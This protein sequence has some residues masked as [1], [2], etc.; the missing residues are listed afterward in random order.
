MKLQ[1][2]HLNTN[3]LDIEEILADNVAKYTVSGKNANFLCPFHDDSNP[4]CGMNIENGLWK[5]FACGEQGN[6]IQFIQ[7]LEDCTYK[8]AEDIVY[9]KYVDKV[10]DISN[11]EEAIAA[12]MAPAFEDHEVQPTFPEWLLSKFPQDWTYMKQRGLSEDTLRFFNIVYDP[13]TKF[14][15]IPVYDMEGRLVGVSGRNTEGNEPK[16]K[17]L[18]RFKKSHFVFN[19]HNI[20]ITKPV[21]GVEG[22]INAMMLHQHGYPNSVAFFSAGVTKG[23]IE[24]M[25]NLGIKEFII[26]FDSDDAGDIGAE[27]LFTGLWRNMVVKKVEDHI[28]DPADM[29]KQQVEQLIENADVYPLKLYEEL[30]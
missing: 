8:E 11:F 16:Y 14:A 15:G 19:V 17:P 27:K 26:F 10:P 28:G 5:C 23:Q 21:I 3:L 25:R 7:K 9:E 12:I 2:R 18:I 22:E 1:T 13:T 6:I 30:V 20:D 4:S 29:T 24:I